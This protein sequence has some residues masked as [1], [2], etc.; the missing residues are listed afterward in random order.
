MTEFEYKQYRA[1]LERKFDTDLKALDRIYSFTKPI[2]IS[3]APVVIDK[4][5]K[6][7]HKKN[8]GTAIV[9]KAIL[10]A[11]NTFKSIDIQTVA[12]MQMDMQRS[13]IDSEIYRQMKAGL[14]SRIS[15]GEFRKVALH[16]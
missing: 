13:V 5:S 11:G 15:K 8:G 4:P 6:M 3:I 14:I 9:R 12:R 2:N 10:D 7:I 16:G 1:E